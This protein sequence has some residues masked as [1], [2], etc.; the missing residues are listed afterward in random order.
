MG[1]RKTHFLYPAALYASREPT[2]VS[3]I[4][5]SCVAVCLWDKQ[6]SIGGINHF[7]LPLWNGQGLAS[8]KYGNIAIEKLVAK[9]ESLGS[10]RGDLVAKVFGGGAVIDTGSHFHIGDRN[11]EMALESL[12]ELGIPVVARSVG[13]T[14]GRKLEYDTETGAVRQRYIQKTM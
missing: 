1:E 6:L 8:P 10:Q 2:T 3:T 12:K 13:G 11:I 9:M 4:L 14:N 5:G 7:M